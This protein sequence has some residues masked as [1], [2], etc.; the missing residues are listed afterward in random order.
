MTN[1]NGG[2]SRTECYRKGNGATA[3]LVTILG[4]DGL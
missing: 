1:L 4:V 2:Y 3:V